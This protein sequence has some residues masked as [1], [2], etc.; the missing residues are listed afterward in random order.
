M[1]VNSLYF[2]FGLGLVTGIACL[3]LVY[4]LYK[5][6]GRKAHITDVDEGIA[7]GGEDIE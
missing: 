2:I 7:F 4:G 6:A 3:F 5:I 1:I